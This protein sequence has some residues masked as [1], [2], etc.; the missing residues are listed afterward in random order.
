MNQHLPGNNQENSSDQEKA[1]YILKIIKVDQQQY[2]IF[3]DTGCCDMVSGYKAIKSIGH[4]AVQEF[5]GSILIG[6]VGKSEITTDHGVYQVKLTLFNGNVATF[7]AICL[8]QITVNFPKYL[9]NGRVEND[10]KYGYKRM[11]DDPKYLAK[12]PG[13]MAGNTDFM[14]GI[15]YLRHYPKIIF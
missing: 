1:I 7:S 15:K 13:F 2:S 6:G 12:L 11:G 14:I 4:R 5:A 9:L 3:H 8:D 10:I